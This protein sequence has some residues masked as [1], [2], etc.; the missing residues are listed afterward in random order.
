LLGGLK[1]QTVNTKW[2]T[3][4]VDRITALIYFIIVISVFIAATLVYPVFLQKFAQI[5]QNNDSTKLGILIFSSLA[6]GAVSYMLLVRIKGLQQKASIVFRYLTALEAIK[7]NKEEFMAILE[8]IERYL[9]NN[10]WTMAE[11]W[12]THI[13]QDYT[14]FLLENQKS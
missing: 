9:D 6:L 1:E 11:Y 12:V 13:I 2:I 14:Q 4:E 10:E 8:D 7:H 3:A 5:F